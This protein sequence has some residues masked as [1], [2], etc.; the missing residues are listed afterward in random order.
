MRPEVVAHRGASDERAEHTLG[1]YVEALDAGADGLECDVRLTADGHLVCFHDRDLRRTGSRRG[2]VSTMDLAEL[3][4]LEFASW[5]NPWADLDDEAPDRDDSLDGVLTLRRLLSTVADCGRR[6]E[7]AIET[8]HPTR[9]AGLVERR[10]VEELRHF[11]WHRGDS[12]VRVMSFS[13]TA[14]QR[15]ERPGIDELTRNPVFASRLVRTGRDIHVWTVNTDAQ[16]QRCLDLG[17]RAVIT[18]RPAY[19]LDLLDA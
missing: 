1:A 6:V 18:D 8:K 5:K 14:L 13:Y 4:Q 7:L 2:V 16:L 9:Y 12:P 3:D 10:L 15:V 11:G 17:V 19:M